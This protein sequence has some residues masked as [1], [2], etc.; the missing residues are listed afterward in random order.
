MKQRIQWGLC[1]ILSS[2]AIAG[3]VVSLIGALSYN[4]AQLVMIISGALIVAVASF[5]LTLL[6]KVLG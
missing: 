3:I 6:A 5:A 1:G 2:F 4:P